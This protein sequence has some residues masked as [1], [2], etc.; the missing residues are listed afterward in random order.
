MKHMKIILAMLVCLMLTLCA[1]ASA[2]T[3]ERA[4]M[5]Y[6]DY[7]GGRAEQSVEDGPTLRLLETMLLR[8]RD[9][10]V[11]LDESTMNAT[12]FC[13]TDDG[14]IYG[15]YCATTAGSPYIYSESNKTAYSLGDDY[16][17]FWEIFSD[18]REGMGYDAS[19][20]FDLDEN[21]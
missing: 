8:A 2:A 5:E 13:M 3:L 16:D 17:A 19:Y 10:V 20:F 6:E 1:T 12:L 7:S 9:N 21:E 11:K 4:W 18:V 14:E 15:F